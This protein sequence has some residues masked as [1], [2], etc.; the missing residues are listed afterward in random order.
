[1]W[2]YWYWPGECVKEEAAP[3][4]G[5]EAQCVQYVCF[6]MCVCVCDRRRISLAAAK[7]ILQRAGPD[8]PFQAFRFL[9]PTPSRPPPKASLALSPWDGQQS[10]GRARWLFLCY[11]VKVLP[12]WRQRQ[13]SL[14][15]SG[16]CFQPMSSCVF[17]CV[18]EGVLTPISARRQEE[19]KE[20]TVIFVTMWA[21]SL[22]LGPSYCSASHTNLQR[23]VFFT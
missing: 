3:V 15:I 18:C 23:S 16:V 12:P 20:M 4:T 7:R 21:H 1:M 14:C 9:R 11:S 10:Q 13:A 17:M 5:G 22:T 8:P 19:G 6:H 2:A